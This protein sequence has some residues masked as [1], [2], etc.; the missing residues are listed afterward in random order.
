MQDILG[1][2]VNTSIEKDDLQVCNMIENS[3]I[4]NGEEG[5]VFVSL[6]KNP[7]MAFVAS[8]IKSNLEF[9]AQVVEDGEIANE[10]QDEFNCEDVVLVGNS[11]SAS[12]FV[13]T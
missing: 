1:V 3:K 4:A 13:I 9:K 12:N 8:E 7:E 5:K 11:S 10:Y 2:S 6:Q